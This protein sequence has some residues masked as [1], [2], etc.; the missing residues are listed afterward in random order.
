DN[1]AINYVYDA[2]N[3]ITSIT[4][5]N[6]AVLE[7]H[8]YDAQRRGTMSSRAGNVEKV[9]VYYYSNPAR[10]YACNSF[11]WCQTYYSTQIGRQSFLGEASNDAHCVTCGVERSVVKQ[12][13]PVTGN[14]TV[15]TPVG[16]APTFYNYDAQGNVI[17]TVQEST[18]TLQLI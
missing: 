14:I 7:S 15:R 11:G 13:H 12:Y 5:T 10:V 3:L 1:A 2:S 18:S 8:T 9:S 6:N 4:D 17:K 16:Q